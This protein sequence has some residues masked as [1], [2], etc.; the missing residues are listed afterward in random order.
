[1][2]VSYLTSNLLIYQE[3]SIMARF[4]LLR[5]IY[6]GEHAIEELKT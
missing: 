4:T 1:M 6:F 3:V 2:I 5:D